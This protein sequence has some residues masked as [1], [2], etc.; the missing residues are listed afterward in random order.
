LIGNGTGTGL[1]ARTIGAT[2]GEETHILTQGE[3]AKHQHGY[4]YTS[5]GVNALAGGGV[6]VNVIAAITTIVTDIGNTNDV[7]HNN[8][9]PFAV[10]HFLIKT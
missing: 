10:V 1:T 2:G 4:N 8:M 3:L 7:P 6:N 9:Q 5:A